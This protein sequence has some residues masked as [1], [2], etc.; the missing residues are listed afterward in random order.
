MARILRFDRLP[1]ERPTLVLDRERVMRNIA[2]MSARAKAAGVGFRPH[3]KTH[4]SALIGDWFRDHGVTG[5]TVSSVAMAEY[6][7]AAGWS[8]ITIAIPVNPRE[9]ARIRELAGLI[10][11]GVLVESRETVDL[12]AES[13]DAPVQVWIKVDA[14]YGRAGIRWDETDRIRALAQRIREQRRLSFA[15]ILAHSGHSYHE[16]R[17]GDIQATRQAVLR[18]HEESLTR[19]QGVREA[20]LAGGLEACAIS[21]GDTPTCSQAEHFRGADEI[22]P[23]NFVFYDLMQL[24]LGSCTGAEIAVAVATP[25]LA[26]YPERRQILLYGGAV[27]LAVQALP[28]ASERR[29][30]GC[31]AAELAGT[32]GETRPQVGSPHESAGRERAITAEQTEGLGIPEMAAP[33]TSLSQEHGIADLPEALIE[34]I[35]CGDI[36]LVYPV[37]SC[38][39][40]NLYDRYV[41]LGGEEIPRFRSLPSA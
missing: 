9:I 38:L 32:T 25:V 5:I 36:V 17:W 27:H 7:A 35:R 23:G 16:V 12:L 34:T 21:V 20:L 22:R 14:G 3:F 13:L 11:L 1:I 39:T 33:L 40:G 10:E 31:L 2:R 8:D 6:F 24:Q 4:Q 26:V 19:L 15:G 28:G 29:W 37:H 41:T 30:F 18:V